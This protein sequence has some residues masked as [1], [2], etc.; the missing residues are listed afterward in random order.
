[1]DISGKVVFWNRSIKITNNADKDVYVIASNDNE[2]S[3]DE[4]EVGIGM[5]GGKFKIKTQ[6]AK[7]MKHFIPIEVKGKAEIPVD[8]K[9]VIITSLDVAKNVWRIHAKTKLLVRR[10]YIINSLSSVIAE[11]RIGMMDLTAGALALSSPVEL[12]DIGISEPKNTVA[13]TKAPQPVDSL[14]KNIRNKIE[15]MREDI[16][17]LV[18]VLEKK[19]VLLFNQLGGHDAVVQ[20]FCFRKRI[21][22]YKH[23]LKIGEECFIINSMQYEMHVKRLTILLHEN[24]SYVMRGNCCKQF[25]HAYMSFIKTEDDLK[26]ITALMSELKRIRD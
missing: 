24:K 12:K 26:E 5:D 2:K 20:D 9:C 7:H 15:S 4:L 6:N 14:N 16:D 13:D 17:K 1:M 18:S 8:S 21:E 11:V 22:M 23:G 10:R 3:L 19:S 25:Y